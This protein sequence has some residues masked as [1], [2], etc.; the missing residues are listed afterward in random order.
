MFAPYAIMFG[1]Y[2]FSATF[3]FSTIGL[4][5]MKPRLLRSSYWLTFVRIGGSEGGAIEVDTILVPPPGRSGLGGPYAFGM[6]KPGGTPGTLLLLLDACL[7]GCGG[8]T[9]CGG[10]RVDT[11][12]DRGCW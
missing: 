12:V 3:A 7:T 8:L 5:G 1:A 2:V 11:P 4:I 10:P 6:S 9:Y